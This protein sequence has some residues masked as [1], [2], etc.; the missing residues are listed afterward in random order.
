MAPTSPPAPTFSSD[1]QR[2]ELLRSLNLLDT[3]VESEFD[4]LTEVASVLTGYPIA[5]ISLV[6]AHRQWFKSHRGLAV[7]E[8]PREFAFCAHTILEPSASMQVVDARQDPRFRENPM[9]AGEPHII[10]YVGVPLL[11]G[12]ERQPIGTLCVIDHQPREVSSIQLKALGALARQ[13]ERLIQARIEGRKLREAFE[14]LSEEVVRRQRSESRLGVVLGASPAGIFITDPSGA[15]EYTNPAWQHMAGIEMDQARGFGWVA[16]LHPEDRTR[17]AGQWSRACAERKPFISQHRFQHG[18]GTVVHAR[19]RAVELREHGQHTGYLGTCED[20]T[21]QLVAEGA[22]SESEKRWKFAIDGAGD[23]LW[24]WNARTNAVFFSD[25]WKSQLGHEPHEI[26]AEFA[27]WD[28]RL[29]PDDRAEAYSELDRHLRGEIPQYSSVH[30]LRCKDGSWKWILARGLVIE[31]ETDGSPLRVVGTHTDLT[32]RRQAEAALRQSQASLLEAQKLSL[33]GDWTFDLRSQVITWSP[34]IFE[35]FDRDPSL[36]PPN[37]E[38]FLAAIHPQDRDA[39]ASAIQRAM[40]LGEPYEI[41]H[42]IVLPGGEVRWLL[43]RGRRVDDSEGN[44]VALAGTSQNITTAVQ[45]REALGAARDTAEQA[46][47]AKAEFLATMSHEIRTPLNGVIGMSELL[48]GTTLDPE[49]YDY[50]EAAHASGVS[51]LALINDILDFS[52]IEAGKIELETVPFNPR[53]LVEATLAM[54][55]EGAQAK[56]IELYAEVAPELPIELRGDPNRLRQIVINLVGNAVK[57][58]DRGEVVVA[59]GGA[60]RDPSTWQL[61]IAVRDTGIGIA[62]EHQGHLF[63]AF[64]QAHS[65]TARHHGGTGLGLAISLQLAVLMGGTIE[66]ASEPGAGSTFT[67]AVALPVV[68]AAS[69]LRPLHGVSI[70]IADDHAGARAAQA[71]T[72]RDAGAEVTEVADVAAVEPALRGTPFDVL[73]ID[74]GMSGMAGCAF[75]KQLRTRADVR[76]PAVILCPELAQRAGVPESLVQAIL[77]RPP[78]RQALVDAVLGCRDLRKDAGREPKRGS[79]SPVARRPL[80]VLVAEDNHT[81][82]LV[83]TAQLRRFGCEVD[84]VGDGREAV[85]ACAAVRYDLVLMDCQMPELD[86]FDASRAIRKAETG[87]E[88]LPIVAL[89]ANALE[90]DRE[91]CLAAGMDDYLT[92]PITGAELRR[93]LTTCGG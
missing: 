16:A 8:T 63:S 85:R 56:G 29:H 89:T 58:T 26:G 57:F 34:Q 76:V 43:G 32:S 87:T 1:E 15:C 31:R 3:P 35:N 38:E 25:T 79:I 53:Q 64:T 23:G 28:S 41:E 93:V 30:R 39:F 51:L 17:V 60:T 9:V 19:V 47:R 73:V 80:R 33:I 72:L 37:Y 4:D 24:D 2:V 67:L 92:K 44:P 61:S 91:R 83:V 42:R 18:D 48:L 74:G 20:I 27:E 13:V 69:G 5:L 45:I 12:D 62:R 86:G 52:K 46:T 71:S 22:L 21:A 7:R 75:L 88:R 70:L 82:Q 36:G 81:N 14:N 90:G 65:A 11:A 49:Q 84:A 77:V 66:L 40:T 59:L 55:A 54:L 68:A 78:R 50:A 6:D 10:A